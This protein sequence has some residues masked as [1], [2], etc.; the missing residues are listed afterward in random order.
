MTS[1][2]R[3]KE[4]EGDLKTIIR[5]KIQKAKVTTKHRKV[6]FMEGVTIIYL[7]VDYLLGYYG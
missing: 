6:N 3:D 4:E 5:S 1:V 7:V 2:G